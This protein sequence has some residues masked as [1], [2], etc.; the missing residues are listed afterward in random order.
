M[1]K[2][3]LI[4]SFLLVCVIMLST[5]SQA[6]E[7][8]IY[9]TEIK[10]YR[11]GL[12]L[13]DKEKYGAAKHAFERA[14]ND[15]EDETSMVYEESTYYQALCA[16]HLFNRNA[17]YLLREFIQQYPESPRV[18]DAY[19]QLG[20]YNYRQKQWDEVIQFFDFI[21]SYDLDVESRNEYLFKK[22]YAFFRLDSLDEAKRNLY[23]LI[24]VP[25]EYYAPA[26]YYYGH[27]SYEHGNYETALKAFKKIE[28]DEKFSRV[29][30]YYI[31]QI[32]YQQERYDSLISY[33][34]P[35]ID[36]PK[37]KRKEEIARLI[38]E[39]YFS[40][41]EFDEAIPFLETFVKESA[42]KTRED[43]YQ[44]GY[45]YYKADRPKEALPWLKRT[46]Y[47]DDSLAQ[48]A[49]Y[50]IAEA[51]MD[52]D[53]KKNA[54]AAYQSVYQADYNTTLSE[55]SLFNFAKLSYELE[56]DP[57]NKAIDAFIQYLKKY[58]NAMRS[59][60][61]YEYLINIY[62]NSKN[63]RSAIA[64]LET[65]LDLDIRFKEVYQ[66]L[67]YNFAVEQFMNG[68]YYESI[69]TF[70]RSLTQPIDKNLA[71]LA[72]YWKADAYYRQ[73]MYS[74]AI[75]SYNA[76]MYN[77]RAI[78]LPEFYLA[79][80]N[81][82]YAYYQ[83]RSY[84]KASSWFRKFLA[85][86]EAD[87]IRTGDALIRTGDCFFVR[88]EYLISLEYYQK[89]INL[90]TRDVDYALYQYA[91]A[92]GVMKR[93]DEK[94]ATLTQLEKDYP[95]S[96]YIDAA[97]F[98][99]GQTYVT[100]GKNDQA[101]AYFNKVVES[102]TNSSFSRKARVNIGLIYYNQDQNEKALVEFKRVVA[103]NPNYADSKGALRGIQNI[104]KESGEI[105]KYEEYINSLAFMNISNGSLDSLTYESTELQYMAGNCANATD[106]FERYLAKFD[107]PIFYLNASFYLAECLFKSG[108]FPD[109]LNYYTNIL[110]KPNSK[111]TEPSLGKAS[112][113]NFTTQEY[114]VAAQQFEQLINIAE[115]PENR[116]NGVIGSMR[117]YVE[118]DQ[119]NKIDTAANRVLALDE[120]DDVLM[121]E[122]QYAKAWAQLNLGNSSEARTRFKAII[123]SSTTE[124]AAKALFYTA[125]SLYEE[126]YLDSSEVL[127][128]QL[129]NFTPTYDYW[130]A[131][132]LILLS[133]VYLAKDD[134]FQA[135]AALESI[136]ENYQGEDNLREVAQ[137]K[138]DK[139]INE[140]Q[141]APPQEEEEIE[142]DMGID[143]LDYDGLFEEEEEIIDEPNQ[144]NE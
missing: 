104:Y 80:Y 11:E 13:Y 4:L 125:E 94:L 36:Q 37:I 109:A 75:E 3:T 51:Y 107:Q 64:S 106:G 129:V 108:N 47:Q 137:E 56:Y 87:S 74:Q 33:G 88:K 121:I 140:N 31:T 124:Y 78:L 44:L 2:S 138:L 92:S 81:I 143:E 122:A 134:A 116:R 32:Y 48:S 24:D 76:F 96:D 25:N 133:D 23:Q 91:Q 58:P 53:D 98:E 65:N 60:Q 22:G 46:I 71:A 136:I 141:P 112:Y 38:G 45:A 55:E 123:N 139:L 119:F 126:N 28:N 127:I 17:E 128:F 118:L 16:M 135:K 86:Q 84:D 14:L 34:T 93:T 79:H 102:P 67:L 35:L 43:D 42:T 63:Y 83:K 130:L 52:L 110:R 61:A 111:F 82:A 1:R 5:H 27:I 59:E 101:L 6:Q 144:N 21:D 85:Y 113:I 10:H 15:I 12:E 73:Q 68:Q 9:R 26:N 142:I 90:G 41:G 50:L 117:C 29:T 72:N 97:R 132:G 57:Y 95:N 103:E 77:P 54:L 131:K 100:K 62:L 120:L 49:N 18:K 115:Y 19:F 8:E 40:K 70:D 20:R 99:L 105:E 69:Q 30:P 89:A 39:S 7:T 66:D 114:E